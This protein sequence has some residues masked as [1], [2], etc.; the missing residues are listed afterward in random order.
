[1]RTPPAAFASLLLLAVA[2]AVMTLP[3]FAQS[4]P[5]PPG[6]AAE[7]AA[8]LRGAID[9]HA[10]CDPD[11]MPR[12]IDGLNLARLAQRHGLRAIVL[13]NHFQPTTHLAWAASRETAGILVFGGVALNLPVG[14]LNPHA[15]D[16]MANTQG[17]LGKVVWL[18]TFDS[19]NQVRSSGQNRPSVPVAREGRLLPETLAVLDAIARHKLVLATGHSSAGET[20][21]LIREAKARGIE[22]IVVTHA[23][24]G[25]VSMTVPQIQ[26]AARAGAFIEFAY[27]ALAG[28][29]RSPELVREHAAAI[30]AIGVEHCILSSDMGQQGNPLHPE[31]LTL[32]ARLLRENGFTAAELEQMVKKNPAKLLG[33]E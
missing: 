3:V 16:A 24:L 32:F 5:T 27:N 33:L 14:G 29:G 21:L 25:P 8:L 15:V 20:L 7:D 11:S 10:H 18:P 6:P 17:A 22:H 13:K 19:E 2:T 9:I 26:E 12:S 1:M 28:T 23:M 30:R 4:P 31:G